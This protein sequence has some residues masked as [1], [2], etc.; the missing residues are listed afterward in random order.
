MRTEPVS[1]VSFV[2]SKTNVLGYPLIYASF[3]FV[4]GHVLGVV[5]E[6]V[7]FPTEGN[8]NQSSTVEDV[9][10]SSFS[11]ALWAFVESIPTTPASAAESALVNRALNRM[12]SFSRLKIKHT[13]IAA[14][15]KDTATMKRAGRKG[16]PFLFFPIIIALCAFCWVFVGNLRLVGRSISP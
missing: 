4:F 8:N 3:F 7:G 6:S 5:Y 12:S 1:S 2:K 16:L 15:G 11:S 13:N 14:A 10:T 9:A